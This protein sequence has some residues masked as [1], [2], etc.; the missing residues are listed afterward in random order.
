MAQAS[1]GLVEYQELLT[2]LRA[3]LDDVE[4]AMKRLD[5]GTYGRCEACGR[6]IPADRLEARPTA[7]RC[8]ACE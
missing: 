4:A 8:P 1:L 6:A 2:N 5:E 7:R 3:D